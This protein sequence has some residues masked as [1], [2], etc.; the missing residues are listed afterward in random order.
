M[1]GNVGEIAND[2]EPLN[3]QIVKKCADEWLKKL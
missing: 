2:E 1:N 3:P